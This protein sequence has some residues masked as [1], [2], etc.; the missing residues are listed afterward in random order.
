MV[1]MGKKYKL[2]LEVYFEMKII[3]TALQKIT[4]YY[5]YIYYG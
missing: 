3:H 4:F 2:F 1:P 5:V